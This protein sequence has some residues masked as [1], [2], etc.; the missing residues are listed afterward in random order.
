MKLPLSQTTPLQQDELG[1]VRVVGSRVTLD[2]IV[3]AFLDGATA[4]QIHDSYPSVSLRDVYATI[5]YYLEHEAAVQEY[6]K[7]QGEAAS[8]LRREIEERQE[9]GL[10]ARLRARRSNLAQP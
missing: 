4:E 9:G 3:R 2:T 5:A 1:T 10:G 6:L 8:A 7:G